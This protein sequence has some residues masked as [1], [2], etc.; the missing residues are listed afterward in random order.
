MLK[1]PSR[2]LP[3]KHFD[4][5]QPFQ[6]FVCRGLSGRSLDS[7][8]PFG[9]GYFFFDRLCRGLSDRPLHPFGCI[10]YKGYGH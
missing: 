7:F 3:E 9:N 2:A 5:N 8:A 4:K 10:L 6:R 1:A